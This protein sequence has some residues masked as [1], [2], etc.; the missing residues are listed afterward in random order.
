MKSPQSAQTSPR[1]RWRIVSPARLR[2]PLFARRKHWAKRLGVAPVLPMTRP[3]MDAL[4][5]DACDVI[6]V[7]RDAYVDHPSFGTALVGRVL[8]EQGFRVGIIAQPAWR[9]AEAFAAL[10]R[11]MVM[12]G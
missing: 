4:G 3:E 6:L 2:P 9:S 5:W 11:P 1:S 7:T 10:G 12:F 8:E